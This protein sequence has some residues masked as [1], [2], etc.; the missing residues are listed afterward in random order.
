LLEPDEAP[1]V[2]VFPGEEEAEDMVDVVVD[3][4]GLEES[5]GWPGCDDGVLSE[6]GH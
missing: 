6:T 5:W 2:D 3:E 1:A 4:L